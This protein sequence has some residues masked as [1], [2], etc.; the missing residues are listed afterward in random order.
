M[1]RK[2]RWLLIALAPIMV[3]SLTAE[4]CEP[5]GNFDAVH[6]YGEHVD[7]AN[8]MPGIDRDWTYFQNLCFTF[9]TPYDDCWPF[10]AVWWYEQ[11]YKKVYV[12]DYGQG[13][14]WKWVENGGGWEFQG[15]KVYHGLHGTSYGAGVPP[16]DPCYF[17]AGVQLY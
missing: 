8:G 14:V 17:A 2:K 9:F 12:Y 1:K 7:F 13:Y 6:K 5:V 4:S 10:D 15:C 16:G 11:W 3:L